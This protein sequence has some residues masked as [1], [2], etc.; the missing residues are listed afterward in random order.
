MRECNAYSNKKKIYW[1]A[2]YAYE[3][4]ISSLIEDRFC[5]GKSFDSLPCAK[6]G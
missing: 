3:T 2:K 1:A 6:K 5:D 4:A